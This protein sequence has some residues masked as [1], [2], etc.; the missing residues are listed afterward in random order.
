MSQKSLDDFKQYLVSLN[1]ASDNKRYAMNFYK[2]SEYLESLKQEAINDLHCHISSGYGNVNSNICFIFPNEES[3]SIVKSLIQ[4]ILKVLKINL[5]DI[6]ITFVDKS[7]QEYSKKYNYLMNELNAIKPS[8]VYVFGKDKSVI[9][10]LKQEYTQYNISVSNHYF[11]FVD[12]Q[13][14][15]SSKEEDRIALWNIFKYMINY[16]EIET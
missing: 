15:A 9:D 12:V 16:R 10:R 4:D 3:L 8:I 1:A 6:Y 11:Q 7:S 13:Q 2:K 14:L 5:W